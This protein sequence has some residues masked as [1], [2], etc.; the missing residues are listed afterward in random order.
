MKEASNIISNYFM[1]YPGIKQYIEDT[2]NSGFK[3]EYVAT[4]FG[5]RRNTINL[6]SLLVL[7]ILSK[8]FFL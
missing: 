6:R 3:D 7:S 8:Y 4:Y 5:R 1:R 2:I